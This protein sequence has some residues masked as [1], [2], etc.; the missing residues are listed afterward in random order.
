MPLDNISASTP[1]EIVELFANYF[2]SSYAVDDVLWNFDNT[3][4]PLQDLTEIN[5]TLDDI[6][7]AINSL[8]WKN[9]AGPG[10][11]S[12]FVVKM[13]AD[14]I[15]WPIW[16]LFQ[17]IFDEGRI[18]AAL[19]MPRVVSVH[20]NG[21]KSDVTKYR[22]AAISSIILKIQEM[23]M[24]TK[25]MTIIEPK[26]ATWISTKTIRNDKSIEFVY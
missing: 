21:A 7:W 13:C 3:V 25:L 26:C 9:G 2:G 1:N 16:L 6:E 23:A 15:V 20:K 22:V 17:K 14:A 11:L 4:R 12:P 10:Q 24:K 8:K 18:P 19:K 5:V